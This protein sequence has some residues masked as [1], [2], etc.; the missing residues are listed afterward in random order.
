MAE[1]ILP[2]RGAANPSTEAEGTNP[3]SFANPADV[4]GPLT[5]S[6]PDAP[7]MPTP[8]PR[9]AWDFLPPGWQRQGA[10]AVP[11]PGFAPVTQLEHARAG[12]VTPEMRRVAER[13]KHLT[14]AQVLGEVAAGRMI[15]PANRVHLG[16]QLDAMCIGRA[17]KTKINAKIGSA[18]VSSSTDEEVENLHFAERWGA[19]TVMDLSTG[20]DLDACREAIIKSSRVPI[21]TVPV[22]S[23]IIGRRIEDLTPKLILESLLKQAQQGVDYFTIHAGVLREHLPFVK[24]RPIG[25]VRRGGSLTAKW[26]LESLLKQAQQGVDYFTI[27]AGVLREHLPF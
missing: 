2:W 26:I 10:R 17:S 22:Y 13:E 24:K 14:P 19:D 27:H 3:G 6:S 21:G 8:S 9:T 4:G 11:P 18:P 5:F 1:P 15:I 20:G 7:G 16:Y 23:M 25:I 12:N